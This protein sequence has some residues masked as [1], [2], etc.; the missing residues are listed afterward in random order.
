VTTP[1]AHLATCSR[2][3]RDR[4]F[5]RVD[6]ASL[7]A[8]RIAFGAVMLYECLAYLA[9]GM[10][11]AQFVEPSFHF[12]YL[13]FGWVA[14]WPGVGMFVHFWVL[15]ALALLIALGLFYRVAIWLFVIGFTY[16][17]LL[18]QAYYLNHYYLVCLLAFLLALM[19]A[20]RCWS[21]AAWRRGQAGEGRVPLWSIWIL[22][23]QLGV[24]YFYAGITKLGSDWLQGGP[25]RAFVRG[26]GKSG[27]VSYLQSE[28]AIFAI[29]W[30]GLVLD[31]FVV[32]F[33]LWR[34]TRPYAFA[35]A[36]LFHLTNALVFRFPIG[37]FPWL[38][39]AATTI[40]FEPDWPRHAW[41]WLRKA[42]RPETSRP[43][44]A[45]DAVSPARRRLVVAFV[46][47]WTLVQVL[48]PIRPYLYPGDVNWNDEGN[49]FA[50]RLMAHH[51]INEA[52]FYA[53]DPDSEEVWV[54]DQEAFLTPTQRFVMP[55]RPDMMLQFADHVASR[56]RAEGRE[57][58]G[59]RAY[60]KT[61]LNGRRPQLYLDPTVDIAAERRSLAHRPWVLPLRIPFEEQ[62]YEDPYA[63]LRTG[64]AP[65]PEG[66]WIVTSEE[67]SDGVTVGRL[68]KRRELV[69][70]ETGPAT[71][72]ITFRQDGTPGVEQ[73]VPLVFSRP[74]PAL[75][76]RI[77]EQRTETR[78]TAGGT[79]PVTTVAWAMW[80]EIDPWQAHFEVVHVAGF[81][82]PHRTIPDVEPRLIPEIVIPADVTA[83]TYVVADG[84]TGR[85]GRYSV[86]VV[87]PQAEIEVDGRP[88]PCIY[89]RTRIERMTKGAVL[90]A[91]VERWLSAAVPG[92]LAKAVVTVRQG[93]G[94]AIWRFQVL[95][96]GGT[97]VR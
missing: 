26:E 10:V 81:S 46:T 36:V 15:A 34:R 85:Q 50:W 96:F 6:G 29:S 3:W 61:S 73:V 59:V 22:R 55:Y 24:V 11:R 69:D 76:M 92:Q 70:T 20:G 64:W 31:L 86:A 41:A 17:F 62:R 5:D 49:M 19:P 68:R 47:T 94:V 82:A 33:L 32:P 89:E 43:L 48:V 65:F 90:E 57:R 79:R 13:G 77:V 21:L 8:F 88:V 67:I 80:D 12:G 27:L 56:L 97:L 63:H 52:R 1:P 40:Y 60:V 39:I 2:S 44:A 25:V 7:A 14:P 42:P 18:E 66:A 87:D 95:E 93:E 91:D 53:F 23:V 78:E 28:A 9:K 35:A 74:A 37:I 72:T 51:K 83:A 84:M 71:R 75:D 30:G 16:V 45:D 54:V 58:V 4:L 38:M